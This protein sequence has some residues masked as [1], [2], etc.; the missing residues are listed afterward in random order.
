MKS[1]FRISSEILNM[2]YMLVWTMAA[3]WA[4]FI[5]VSM[6]F[7]AEISMQSQGLLSPS[8]MSFANSECEILD[9]RTAS[10]VKVFSSDMFTHMSFRQLSFVNIRERSTFKMFFFGPNWNSIAVNQ[11]VNQGFPTMEQ[12]ANVFVT[13]SILN[14]FQL[15]LF[16]RN[17]KFGLWASSFG[18]VTNISSQLVKSQ[19]E[20]EEKLD[21]FGGHPNV[22][23]RAIPSQATVGIGAVEGVTTRSLTPKNNG[24]HETPARK[25]RYSLSWLDNSQ[26]LGINSLEITSLLIS[27]ISPLET[28]FTSNTGTTEAKARLHE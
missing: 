25:G 14:V 26:N 7:G 9:G 15:N 22:K 4:T 1:K 3:S 13:P 23:S 11:V 20:N 10:P 21:E 2:M 28:W 16:F 5:Q 27:N 18:H 6:A 8:V 12:Q 24:S 19:R 17:M